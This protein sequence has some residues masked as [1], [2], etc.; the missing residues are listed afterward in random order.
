MKN[1]ARLRTFTFWGFV[2]LHNRAVIW[3]AAAILLFVFLMKARQYK[4]HQSHRALAW[5]GMDIVIVFLLD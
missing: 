3:K 4:Q 5:H 2:G 1:C